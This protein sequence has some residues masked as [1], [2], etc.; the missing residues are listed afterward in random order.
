MD[1]SFSGELVAIYSTS[2]LPDGYLARSRLEAEGIPVILKG[3]GEGP[4]RM[5]PAHILVPVELEV[6]ARLILQEII[7]GRV[8]VSE[9]EDLTVEI[10]W[11]QAEQE[12]RRE[13]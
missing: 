12:P 11:D 4:Y 13:P 9:D 10:D 3:E 5:G 2:S 7:D 8:R 1:P 6:Q